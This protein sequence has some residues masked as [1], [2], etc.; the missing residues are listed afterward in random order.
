MHTHCKWCL[1]EVWGTTECTNCWEIRKRCEGN[2]RVGLLIAMHIGQE[3]LLK[4]IRE[5]DSGMDKSSASD[6]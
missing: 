3:F 5:Y 1:C 6:G 2:P 4:M